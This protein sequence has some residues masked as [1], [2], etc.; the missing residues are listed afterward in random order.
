MRLSGH[1]L[2][3]RADTRAQV[4][5]ADVVVVEV[6]RFLDRIFDH[7]LG[8]GSEA[9]LPMVTMSGPDW[10]IFSTS[11]RI[12]QVDVQFFRTLAATPEPSFNQPEKDVLGADVLVVEALRLWLASCSPCGPGGKAFIHSAVSDRP[13]V[14]GWPTGETGSHFCCLNDGRHRY[15]SWL[16]SAPGGPCCSAWRHPETGTPRASSGWCSVKKVA[17]RSPF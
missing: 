10:T 9:V 12:S 4:F 6:P 13:A 15:R 16:P 11:R 14:V 1:A 7:F 8:R 5:G 2:A 17:T 3:A